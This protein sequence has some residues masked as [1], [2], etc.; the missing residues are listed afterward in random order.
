VHYIAWRDAVAPMMAS[1]R[2]SEKYSN[3]FP[4]VEGW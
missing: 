2:T 3:V 1:P 4:E